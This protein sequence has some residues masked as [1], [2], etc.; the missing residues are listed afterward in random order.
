MFEALGEQGVQIYAMG[1]PVKK[2]RV[3]YHWRFLI[4][5]KNLPML[6]IP[7][8]WFDP[9]N[10]EITVQDLADTLSDLDPDNADTYQANAEAYI[11]Q[12]PI[13]VCMGRRRVAF[14]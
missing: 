7:T 3:V 4:S 9:R 13:A 1:E 12:L 8:F 10:W 6:M 14:C 11:E 5:L 2:C